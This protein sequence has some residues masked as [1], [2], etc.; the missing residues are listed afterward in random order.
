MGWFSKKIEPFPDRIY[1]AAFYPIPGVSRKQLEK[2]Y[3]KIIGKEGEN[4]ICDFPMAAEVCNNLSTFYGKPFREFDHYLSCLLATF[5]FR[6]NGNSQKVIKFPYFLINE[7]ALETLKSLKQPSY[8]LLD[9]TENIGGSIKQLSITHHVNHV[10]ETDREAVIQYVLKN[11]TD[12]ENFQKIDPD[13][14][15]CTDLDCKQSLYKYL[16]LYG[17]CNYCSEYYLSGSD[18][19]KLVK[20]YIESKEKE[21]D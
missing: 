20:Q 13:N 17:R 1:S 10:F 19:E 8:C 21:E 4:I 15:R 16:G 7:P 14:P 3:I 11:G 6:N 18:M 12:I 5:S 9:V 2:D